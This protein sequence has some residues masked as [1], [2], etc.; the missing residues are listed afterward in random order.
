MNTNYL[1]YYDI[2][3]QRKNFQ[4]AGGRYSS[5][6]N[7]TDNQSLKYFK[8]FFHFYNGSASDSDD[9]NF[10]GGLISPIFETSAS[11]EAQINWNDENNLRAYTCAWTYLKLN[12]EDERASRLEQFIRLLSNIS[13][14]APWYFQSIEGLEGAVDR[15]VNDKEFKID[16]ERKALTIKCLADAVD[17][18]IGTL[19]DLYRSIVYSYSTRRYV[20]P[21]NLRKFDMSIIVFESPISNIHQSTKLDESAIVGLQSFSQPEQYMTSYKYYEFHNCEIN[22]NSSKTATTLNNVEGSVPEYSIEVYFDDM[23]ENRYN[24]YLGENIGD[25]VK[26]DIEWLTNTDIHQTANV[27]DAVNSGIQ[28]QKSFL[29]QQKITN[30]QQTQLYQRLDMFDNQNY[31]PDIDQRKIESENLFG[32]EPR[33]PS[34]FLNNAIGEVVNLGTNYVE[35]KVKQAILGNLNGF[36]LEKA[37]TQVQSL[38]KGDVIG[39]YRNVEGYINNNNIKN[40]S[41]RITK[42]SLFESLENQQKENVVG[43]EQIEHSSIYGKPKIT[44]QVITRKNIFEKQS[45]ANNI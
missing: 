3:N 45:I 36:S 26:E 29:L 5:D 9:N 20:L 4:L 31:K 27:F 6:F 44:Q 42:S 35:S 41:D 11:S 24:E 43:N 10:S 23:Y 30:D 12:C 8:L 1:S 34:N 2:V 37:A 40:E 32:L 19:L 17:D 14:E 13:S 22:Y 18:R 7:Q 15:G 21:A 28:Q 33:V 39:T 38:L 16:E 25:F